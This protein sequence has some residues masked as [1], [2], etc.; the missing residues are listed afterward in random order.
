MRYESSR[1]FGIFWQSRFQQIGEYC[2][3]VRFSGFDPPFFTPTTVSIMR[4]ESS[5]NFGIF[6]KIASSSS[7][8]IAFLQ[9]FQASLYT[10]LYGQL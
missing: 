7:V 9:G 2:L 8:Q 3:P 10:S 6:G 1:N 4:H 5:R